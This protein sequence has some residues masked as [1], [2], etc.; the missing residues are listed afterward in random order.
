MQLAPVARQV[1]CC[2][3]V[4]LQQTLVCGAVPSAEACL[5]AS[6]PE[7]QTHLHDAS[8]STGF[9]LGPNLWPAMI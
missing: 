7:M 9:S 3:S 6:M 4:C 5:P 8:L 1:V 2:R